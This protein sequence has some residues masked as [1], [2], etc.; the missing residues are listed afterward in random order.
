[1]KDEEDITVCR[2]EQA[3]KTAKD[4]RKAVQ[5]PPEESHPIYIGE[6]AQEPTS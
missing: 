2:I 6:E 4:F 5:I 1:M 3:F